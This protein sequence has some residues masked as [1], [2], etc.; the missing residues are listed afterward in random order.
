MCHEKDGIPSELRA[1][2]QDTTNIIYFH[3]CYGSHIWIRIL[4]F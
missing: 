4:N 1:K 3:N 2:A